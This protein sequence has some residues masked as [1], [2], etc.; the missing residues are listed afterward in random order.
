MGFS[1]QEYGSG[2]PFPSPGDLPDP[3]IE[4]VSPALLKLIRHSY[5]SCLLILVS[6]V[7]V[8]LLLQSVVPAD[9]Y[10]WCLFPG[11]ILEL[12]DLN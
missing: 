4:P 3:G 6:L 12:F 1:K 11:V 2:L 5:F 9:S 7:L 10:S 8:G